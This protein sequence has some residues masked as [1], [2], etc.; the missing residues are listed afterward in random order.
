MSCCASEELRDMGSSTDA[1]ALPGEAT[2]GAQ[3]QVWAICILQVPWMT[4]ICRAWLEKFC[5]FWTKIRS[6][7]NCFD[8]QGVHSLGRET[9]NMVKRKE[10]FRT[11]C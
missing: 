11:K 6:G 10:N 7:K 8:P 1:E 5:P 2:S 4:P 9:E 3:G